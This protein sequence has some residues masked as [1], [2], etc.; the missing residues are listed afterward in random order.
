MHYMPYVYC[1]RLWTLGPLHY[2]EINYPPDR[3]RLATLLPTRATH[4]GAHP[5]PTRHPSATRLGVRPQ[6][7][8]TADGSSV[9]YQRKSSQ[10]VCPGLPGLS[11]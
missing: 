7:R 9:L 1:V 5:S 2:R 4:E 11:F 3:P 10:L 6:A 8:T